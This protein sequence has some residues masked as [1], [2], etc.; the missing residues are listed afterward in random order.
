MK[1]L[2]MSI[3]LMSLFSTTSIL[4]NSGL[5]RG[6]IHN[7][8]GNLRDYTEEN[9]GRVYTRKCEHKLYGHDEWTTVQVKTYRTCDKCG[10]TVL[11]STSSYEKLVNCH[12]YST[13]N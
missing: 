9:P 3:A 6:P 10:Y 5:L 2:L 13:E 8:G 7:C 4:A 12:G 1:K 11:L